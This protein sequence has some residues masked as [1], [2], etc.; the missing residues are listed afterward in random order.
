MGRVLLGHDLLLR[1]SM[2][3]EIRKKEIQLTDLIQV[4][5]KSVSGYI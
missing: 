4:V 2:K 3:E 5:H 1:R